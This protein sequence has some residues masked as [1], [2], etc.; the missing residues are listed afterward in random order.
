MQMWIVSGEKSSLK[1]CVA[2]GQVFGK[3][4]KRN[5]AKRLLRELFRRMRST[6]E[7]K[8]DILL[9]A[10]KPILKENFEN[11]KKEF[12]NNAEKLGIKIKNL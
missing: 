12:I 5:R 7:A 8:Y 10:R 3:A 4:V 11:L 1:L 9:I 6:L 2:A